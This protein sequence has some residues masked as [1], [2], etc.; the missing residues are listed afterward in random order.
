MEEIWGKKKRREK[1]GIEGEAYLK[2]MMDEGGRRKERRRWWGQ[3][4]KK[5]S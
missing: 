3:K 1:V 5:V 4:G 2:K